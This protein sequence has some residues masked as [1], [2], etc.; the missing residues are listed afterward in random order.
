MNNELFIF[1]AIYFDQ[2]GALAITLAAENADKVDKVVLIDAQ[3]R[4]I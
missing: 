4:L 3:V 2:G 1:I